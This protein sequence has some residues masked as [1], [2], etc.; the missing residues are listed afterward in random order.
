[1]PESISVRMNKFIVTKIRMH[2]PSEPQLLSLDTATAADMP[3][4][5]ER[6][7]FRYSGIEL[8]MHFPLQTFPCDNYTVDLNIFLRLCSNPRLKIKIL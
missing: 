4:F 8:I 6:K 5:E 1:M 7:I 3:I 2:L